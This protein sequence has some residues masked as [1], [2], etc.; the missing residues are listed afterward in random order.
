MRL[1]SR[2]VLRLT[3][4]AGLALLTPQRGPAQACRSG[5]VSLQTRASLLLPASNGIAGVAASPSGTLVLWS[6]AGEVF[7]IDR[8]RSITRW[9]L[10]DSIHPAGAAITAEGLRFYDLTAREYLRRPD[11]SIALLAASPIG[12][13]EQVDQALWYRGGWVVGLRDRASRTFVV[14]RVA[15]GGR[16]DLFRSAPSDSVRTI[17]RYHLTESNGGLLLTRTMAPFAVMRLDPQTG[18]VDTL[19][20]ILG[21][22]AFDVPADR[23][24]AWRALP[25]VSFDCTLLLTL[26]DLT[27]DR[28]LLVRYGATDQVEQVT[29][30]D[31]PLGLIGRLP[32]E[33]VVLAA[34]RAGEL[35]LVWYD[36]HWVRE[37]STT[38]P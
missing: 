8:S 18:T 5:P 3:L 15:P 2:P 10:P 22:P 12:M 4:S 7:V 17:Q 27:A 31:A 14:R 20:A 37:P 34:R 16:S 9:Q 21:N 38:T 30:L 32:E 35:E 29:E 19:E 11:G 33:N 26:T 36:W 13:A 6:L 1:L 23:L 28:R 24:A 25:A